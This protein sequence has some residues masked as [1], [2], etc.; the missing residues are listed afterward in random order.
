MGIYTSRRLCI[1]RCLCVYWG[2]SVVDYQQLITRW[3]GRIVFKRVQGLDR[4]HLASNAIETSSSNF[5]KCQIAFLCNLPKGK[6]HTEE[7]RAIGVILNV[8]SSCV[9]NR[10][11]CLPFRWSVDFWILFYSRIEMYGLS[12]LFERKVLSARNIISEGVWVYSKQRV[13]PYT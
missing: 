12:W 4:G 11:K 9:R 3:H 1:V 2:S 6:K 5:A 8:S 10:N 13:F 7:A